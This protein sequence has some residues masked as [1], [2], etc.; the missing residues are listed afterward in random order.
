LLDALDRVGYGGLV[1]DGA[2]Y[3][4]AIN[5]TGR[6]KLQQ[7]MDGPPVG[8]DVDWLRLAARRLLHRATPWFPHDAD[9]WTTIS[10]GD[11]ACAEC[12]ACTVGRP[13]ALFRRALSGADEN[14]SGVLMILADF[15]AVPEP[16]AATLRRLFGLT[17]T[18]A[19]L[20]AE[21]GRGDNVAY[22]AR[23]H[24]LRVATVRTHLAAIF[25]KT[26]TRR[27]AELAMLLART[28]ILP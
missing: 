7:F 13:M 9:A 2:G 20:A 8:N 10:D 19:K 24:R 18:E 21:I 14:G 27:Q 4:V 23:S 17:A 15:G 11:D 3:V 5:A 26:Q 1:V 6:R 25:A 28:A 12:G 16:S 22:I